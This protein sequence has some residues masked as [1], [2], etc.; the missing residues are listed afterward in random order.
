MPEPLFSLERA[1]AGEPDGLL[2]LHHGR[3]T[4]ERDLLGLADLL[5]PERRLRVVTPRAPLSLP[6]SPGYHWYLVPRVGY[7]D[8]ATFEA[9]RGAL[10]GLHDRLW[11]ETGIGPGR[12]V[13]GGFSMGAVMSYAM[14]LGA[15]RPAVAGIL[16]F[17]G[18]VPTVE[19]WEPALADRAQ[20]RA[21][22]SHGRR[23]PVIGIEFAERARQLLAGGGL[24]LTYRES[25]LG[26]QIDPSHLRE[27]SGWLG[28]V[29][30]AEPA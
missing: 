14:A 10:A 22:V 9:A 23:D 16:A 5:D 30:A 12:T 15:D 19:G 4:D 25:E 7:P 11:E 24:D 26:H 17:S 21:F 6:A 28:E 3:G 8:R 18:F 1:A 20:T 2:V 27:A 29:L 13:L